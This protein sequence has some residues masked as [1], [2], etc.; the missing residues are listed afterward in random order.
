MLVHKGDQINNV[1]LITGVGSAE[2][3][4]LQNYSVKISKEHCR[5]FT[6]KR[7]NGGGGH[8]GCQPRIEVIVKMPAKSRGIELSGWM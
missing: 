7:K 5:Y 1:Q 2:M 3:S 6:K 4:H 8:G